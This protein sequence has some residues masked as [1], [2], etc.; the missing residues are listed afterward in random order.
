MQQFSWERPLDL[1]FNGKENW[2]GDRGTEWK[3]KER[4]EK[5]EGRKLLG[6]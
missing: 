5:R 2:E 3:E 4:G 1:R 6:R